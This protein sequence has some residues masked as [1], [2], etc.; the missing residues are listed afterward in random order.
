MSCGAFAQ[1]YPA[2]P[3]RLVVPF[4]AGSGAD[5]LSRIVAPVLSERLGQPMFV[6]NRSGASGTIGTELAVKAPADGYTLLMAT[7]SMLT[8]TPNLRKVS[9]LPARAEILQ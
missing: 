2:K 5:I 8:V 1:A 7:A 6:D 9:Y 4:S 3:I